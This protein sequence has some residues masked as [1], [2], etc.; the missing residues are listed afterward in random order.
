MSCQACVSSQSAY[1]DYSRWACL[2]P[3]QVWQA[4]NNLLSRLECLQLP[5]PHAI[6]LS[7]E[8]ISEFQLLV[9]S[10]SYIWLYPCAAALLSSSFD[11]TCRIW[12]ACNTAIPPIVLRVDPLQFGVSCTGMTRWAAKIKLQRW[13]LAWMQFARMVCL[14]VHHVLEQINVDSSSE[15][16][17]DLNFKPLQE[18]FVHPLSLS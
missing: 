16:G 13:P 10:S 17:F 5:A 18:A 11:G 4:F 8:F 7:V 14:H 6:A 9:L 12:N 15:R 3:T 1:I 2:Y